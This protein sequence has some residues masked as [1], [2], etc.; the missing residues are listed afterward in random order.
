MAESFLSF[1]V[2]TPDFFFENA[3]AMATIKKINTSHLRPE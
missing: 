3:L 2:H 1:G